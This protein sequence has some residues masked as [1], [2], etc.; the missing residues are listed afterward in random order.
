MPRWSSDFSSL[1]PTPQNALQLTNTHGLN[2]YTVVRSGSTLALYLGTSPPSGLVSS[3]N[4]TLPA[5]DLLGELPARVAL[6]WSPLT[7]TISGGDFPG[8]TPSV[9]ISDQTRTLGPGQSRWLTIDP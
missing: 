4:L 9:Q 5:N 2:T 8:T 1:E 7:G 3:L 6:L